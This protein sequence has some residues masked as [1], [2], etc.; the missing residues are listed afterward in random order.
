MLKH[1]NLMVLKNGM[2]EILTKKKHFKW[3]V[4]SSDWDEGITV[5]TFIDSYNN[6]EC[7]PH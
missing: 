5:Q 3:F 6:P 2:E 4:R 7:Y 1:L